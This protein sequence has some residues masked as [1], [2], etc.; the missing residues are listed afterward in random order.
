MIAS[1]IF[2]FLFIINFIMPIIPN[3]VYSLEKKVVYKKILDCTSDYL[4]YETFY[5]KIYYTETDEEYI[6]LTASAVDLYYP[7]VLNEFGIDIDNVEKPVFIIFPNQDT[8]AFALGLQDGSTPMGVYYGGII[9]ILSPEI[10]IKGGTE[11]E[12]KDRFLREGPI[13]HELVHFA[14]DLKAKGNY[15]LWFT[16]GVALYYENKFTAFEW[17]PDLNDVSQHIT[18]DDLYNDFRNIDEGIAY[19]SSFNA[20]Y[21]FV[22]E[23]GEEALQDIVSKLGSGSDLSDFKQFFTIED[24]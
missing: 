18:I 16:E 4:A 24:K 8:L 20:I 15:P 13:I 17:R 6:N 14:V 2:L 10:W 11:S 9:N 3:K 23:Y 5:C 22:S 7:L 1:I 21:N 12:T 19:R